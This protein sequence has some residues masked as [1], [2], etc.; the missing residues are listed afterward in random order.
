IQQFVAS[1]SFRHIFN[2]GARYIKNQPDI[3]VY[4]AISTFTLFFFIFCPLINRN[5]SPIFVFRTAAKEKKSFT[6]MRPI[7]SCF[8]F[9]LLPKKP[10]I[11]TLFTLSFLPAAINKVDHLGLLGSTLVSGKM[12]VSTSPVI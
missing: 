9:A 5:T 12:I 2:R 10:T 6:S 8:N 7:S 11:S 1:Q 4:F 3:T